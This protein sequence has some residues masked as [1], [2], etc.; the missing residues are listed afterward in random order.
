MTSSV[1][2]PQE[3]D[4][5]YDI[6]PGDEKPAPRPPQ[7]N[8]IQA[9]VAVPQKKP[10]GKILGYGRKIGVESE[11]LSGA[12]RGDIDDIWEGNKL[13]NLYLPIALIVIAC[14][15]DFTVGAFFSGNATTGM[16]FAAMDLG[17]RVGVSVP[18]MLIACFAAVKLLDVSFGPIGPAILK[19]TS[20]AIAP[21]AVLS[22]LTLAG[23]LLGGAHNA[24]LGGLYGLLLGW[25]ASLILYWWLF[26]Y[27]FD[28]QFAE[29]LK[30]VLIVWALRIVGG[31]A[32]TL[33]LTS[34]IQALR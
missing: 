25:A 14:A 6:A 32:A 13:K 22:L 4:A 8:A 31:F 24:I 10:V 9:V 5:L 34:L 33:L 18:I 27:Y 1:A 20:I 26:H 21:F 16:N 17:V 28:L 30:V 2:P 3:E 15:V 7:P 11:I 23:I 12:K 29:V 19:L